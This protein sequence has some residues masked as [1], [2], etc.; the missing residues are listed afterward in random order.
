ML[1]LT[2]SCYEVATYVIVKTNAYAKFNLNAGCHIYSTSLGYANSH[3]LVKMTVLPP[4]FDC[5]ERISAIITTN[6]E[7]RR[8]GEYVLQRTDDGRN[9]R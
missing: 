9:Y 8:W 1:K 5:Y 3:L 7:F 4:I 2:E 6:L